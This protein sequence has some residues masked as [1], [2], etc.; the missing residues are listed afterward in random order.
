[1]KVS[2]TNDNVVNKKKFSVHSNRE[3]IFQSQVVSHVPEKDQFPAINDNSGYRERFPVINKPGDSKR[4]P[5]IN[6]DIL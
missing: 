3:K 5:I 1:M 6:D 2:M 4:F